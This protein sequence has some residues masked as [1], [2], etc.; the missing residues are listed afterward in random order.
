MRVVGDQKAKRAEYAGE[1]RRALAV[2][3]SMGFHF[4]LTGDES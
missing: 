4:L 1:A 2:Y 3:E